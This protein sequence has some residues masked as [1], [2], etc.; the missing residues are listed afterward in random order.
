[1][2]QVKEFFFKLGKGI[3]GLLPNDGTRKL[4]SLNIDTLLES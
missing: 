1:M 2:E 3:C 4:N